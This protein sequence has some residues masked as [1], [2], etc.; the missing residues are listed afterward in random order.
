MRVLTDTSK[1]RGIYILAMESIETRPYF[2]T[3]RYNK[4]FLFSRY[5]SLAVVRDHATQ[6]PNRMTFNDILAL[7]RSVCKRYGVSILFVA[8]VYRLLQA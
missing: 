6:T 5:E 4:I 7:N 2:P 3:T 1:K 8:A